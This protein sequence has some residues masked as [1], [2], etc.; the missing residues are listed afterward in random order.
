MNEKNQSEENDDKSKEERI[1]KQIEK[2]NICPYCQN[3]VEFIWVHGHYQCP[4]C[5]NIVLG[6]CGDE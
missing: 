6:C 3:T 2:L 5:K 4:L 1:K